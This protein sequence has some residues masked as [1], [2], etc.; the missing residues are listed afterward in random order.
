MSQDRRVPGWRSAASIAV[1]LLLCASIE[2]AAA[3]AAPVV[4]GQSV[5]AA[6]SAWHRAYAANDTRQLDA[7]LA[8]DATIVES[9]GVLVDKAALL[10]R[11]KLPP[12]ALTLSASDQRVRRS[13]NFALVTSTVLEKRGPARLEF[14][15]TD[16]FEMK[17][18]GWKLASSHWTRTAGDLTPVTLPRP[19]VDRLAGTYRTPRGATLVVA[20]DGDQLRVTE[21]GGTSTPLVAISPTTFMGP[22]GRV[23][24]M[25]IAEPSGAIGHAVIANLNALTLLSRVNADPR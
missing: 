14:R 18:G 7:L 1:A 17:N 8:E 21:P 16:V 10:A 23:R 24:W 9:G 25:F 11:G 6:Q 2:S 20:R 12:I 19:A 22:A 13:G 15:V 4:A 3:A 5:L